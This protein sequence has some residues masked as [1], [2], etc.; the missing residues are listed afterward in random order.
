MRTVVCLVAVVMICGLASGSQ[1][2]Q[3]L[4]C[5]DW[6]ILEEGVTCQEWIPYPCDERDGDGHLCGFSLLW[7]PR[8]SEAF[9]PWVPALA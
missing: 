4:D 6:V 7:D 2:G 1:P 3:P 9:P 5:E 8:F